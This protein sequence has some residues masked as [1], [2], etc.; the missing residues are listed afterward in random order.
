LIS[1]TWSRNGDPRLV[2]SSS[3]AASWVD[4]SVEYGRSPTAKKPSAPLAEPGGLTDD[5]NAVSARPAAIV[6]QRFRPELEVIDSVLRVLIATCWKKSALR[7]DAKTT[8]T[9]WG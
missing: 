5:N 1:P 2:P 3:S 8:E 6:K 9:R 7:N 4:S